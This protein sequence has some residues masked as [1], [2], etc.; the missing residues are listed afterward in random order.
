MQGDFDFS[1]QFWNRWYHLTVKFYND[2]IQGNYIQIYSRALHKS[3]EY[4]KVLHLY[5]T[6]Q[7]SEIFT[8]IDKNRSTQTHR[9]TSGRA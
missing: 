6:I 1:T 2:L 5:L 7:R 4:Q 8:H 3:H 9:E